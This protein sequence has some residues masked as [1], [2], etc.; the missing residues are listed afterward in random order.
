VVLPPIPTADELALASDFETGVVEVLQAFAGNPGGGSTSSRDFFTYTVIFEFAASTTQ[1]FAIQYD[2][3]VAGWRCS[4]STIG[5]S[6]VSPETTLPNG[7]ATQVH[8]GH[9]A[10]EGINANLVTTVPASFLKFPVNK[11]DVLHVKTQSASGLCSVFLCA[12]LP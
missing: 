7:G 5:I 1:V 12:Y 2:G 6:L 4:M 3:F 11:G 8:V 10:S 9:I